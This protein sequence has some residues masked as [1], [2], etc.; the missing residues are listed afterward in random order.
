MKKIL[1]FR[2]AKLG[3][4]LI[5]VPSI[6]IIKEKYKKSKIYFLTSKNKHYKELP[7]NIENLKL[8][9]KFIFFQNNFTGYLKILSILKKQKIDVVYNLQENT[10]LIRNIKHYF[11]FLLLGIKVKKG[12]FYKQLNYL[13]YNETFQI[14]KRVDK[15]IKAKKLYKLSKIKTKKDKKFLNGKYLTISIGGFSQPKIWDIK[16]WKVLIQNILIKYNINIIITG[17]KKDYKNGLILE[18]INKNRVFSYC[19]KLTLKNLFN[20]IKYSKMHITNDNGSM[21][22]ST[23]YSKETICLFSNHDP[24]GKWFPCNK[25]AKIL[26]SNKGVNNIKPRSVLRSISHFI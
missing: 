4:Y 21:H 26:I 8:V 17:T 18:M 6:Q 19:G 7:K 2:N 1:I 9:D 16:N 14:S 11:F 10:T 25:N 5:T 22:I 20:V 23:L 3:D 12:F 15:N 24:K 13:K